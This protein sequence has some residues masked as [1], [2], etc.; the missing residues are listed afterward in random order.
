MEDPEHLWDWYRKAELLYIDDL[1]QGARSEA[2]RRMAFEL[3]D[4]R[5][6][7]DLITILSS[8][9]TFERLLALDEAIAGRIREK[10]GPYLV[11]IDP[12]KQK[13]YRF[14]SQAGETA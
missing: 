12:G 9:L 6:N 1:F 5:Y 13:N 7:N 3:L 2:D 11:N 8:E 10:C 14:H 4:Y